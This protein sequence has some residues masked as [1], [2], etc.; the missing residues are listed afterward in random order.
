MDQ[1][2][3]FGE[4]PKKMASSVKKSM[5]A[6]RAM[7]KAVRSAYKIADKMKTVSFFFFIVL[8]ILV[9]IFQRT[10]SK[11]FQSGKL[12]STDKEKFFFDPFG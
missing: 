12:S 2:G 11:T 10:R 6:S 8:E 1:I 4:I 9:E 5:V 7:Y 3:P